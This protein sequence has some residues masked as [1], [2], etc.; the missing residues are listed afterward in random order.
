MR[1]KREMGRFLDVCQ[2]TDVY[3]FASQPVGPSNHFLA[4]PRGRGRAVFVLRVFAAL[5]EC[6]KL[7]RDKAII[8]VLEPTALPESPIFHSQEL[9]G[10]HRSRT[11]GACS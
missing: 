8:R 4:E 2:L 10:L 3:P 7:V 6:K 5:E 9:G 1:K 11:R